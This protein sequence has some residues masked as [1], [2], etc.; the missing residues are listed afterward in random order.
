[1]ANV[2]FSDRSLV[3]VTGASGHLGGNLVRAL[4]GQ[5]RR[6]RTLIHRQARALDGLPVEVVKGDLLDGTSLARACAGVT[7]V[8]HLAAS[9]SAGWERSA[10]MVEVNVRGTETVAEA[11]TS[12]RCKP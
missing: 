2:D 10:R 6:V 3:L 12:A 4:L 11:C 5:G 7:T 8:F 9:V 1:M